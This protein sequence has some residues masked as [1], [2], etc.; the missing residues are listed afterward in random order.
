MDRLFYASESPCVD[1]GNDTRHCWR[2]EP[3]CRTSRSLGCTTKRL[4]NGR[5]IERA[6]ESALLLVGYWNPDVCGNGYHCDQRQP[7]R[8]CN[9]NQS[10]DH[11]LSP[12]REDNLRKSLLILPEPERIRSLISRSSATYESGGRVLRVFVDAMEN[13]FRCRYVEIVRRANHDEIW[14][15]RNAIWRAVCCPRCT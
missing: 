9:N 6:N 5:R 10:S 1:S 2:I 12:T 7:N 3:A 13:T 11:R 14:I 15:H 8:D 4:D